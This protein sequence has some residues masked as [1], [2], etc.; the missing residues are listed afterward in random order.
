MNDGRPDEAQLLQAESWTRTT[1]TARMRVAASRP[2]RAG[3]LTL[4][5]MFWDSLQ[6]IGTD[7]AHFIPLSGFHGRIVEAKPT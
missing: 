6:R 2:G 4:R 5:L 7:N 3:D 1:E